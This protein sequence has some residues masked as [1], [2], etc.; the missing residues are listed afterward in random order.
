MQQLPDDEATSLPPGAAAVY[1]AVVWAPLMGTQRADYDDTTLVARLRDYAE[2]IEASL[3]ERA[4]RRLGRG[5]DARVVDIRPGGSARVTIALFGPPI[6]A[7]ARLVKRF[8]DYVT[9]VEVGI[10]EE[11]ERAL[12]APVHVRA[13]L[14]APQAPQAPQATVPAAAA[15]PADASPWD[16]VSPVLGA[17][18]S[19]L[20][21]AGFVTFVGGA[22]H[23]ARFDGA[24]LPAE[25]AVS[26]VPTQ[27][28]AVTGAGVL[29]PAVLV[30]LAAVGL[31]F[32]FRTLT[33]PRDE[34][35]PARGQEIAES[36]GNVIRGLAMA[37]G[38]F[39]G[40]LLWFVVTVDEPG[41][42][43]IVVAVLVGAFAIILTGAVAS[44]TNRFLYLATT[45]FLAFSLFLSA[46]SFA[47]E[48]DASDVRATALVRQN[49]KATIGFFIA[50][51][52]S[53][54]YLG[55]LELKVVDDLTTNEFVEREQ[56]LIAVD[57]S[58]VTDFAIGPPRDPVDALR[59][60]QRLADELCDAQIPAGTD[61]APSSA[62]A[63]PTAPTRP[64]PNCWNRLAGG[65]LP[66]PR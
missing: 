12:G 40:A 63:K 16:R 57:K 48:R 9:D 1:E 14:A 35:L 29:A 49:K 30:A 56:R 61:A 59:Q 52:S 53:R 54:V 62:K 65:E 24:G 2:P 38:V 8:R 45:T 22:V 6:R 55:R 18:A 26:V 43:E 44:G 10:S 11:L 37:G 60:A 64:G 20:G 31:L 51:T 27:N 19:G 25:E 13:K 7:G 15:P 32:I 4:R 46:V 58:Q 39:V 28:L 36:Y 5:W 23:W 33:G 41:R 50:E 17:V 21:V 34:R 3:S 42:W 47:R 66:P